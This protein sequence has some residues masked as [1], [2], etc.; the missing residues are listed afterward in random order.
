MDGMVNPIGGFK[1]HARLIQT[2][3]DWVASLSLSAPSLLV[4]PDINLYR[5]PNLHR[6]S[7]IAYAERHGLNQLLA[8]LCH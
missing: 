2:E 4:F 6:L 5:K 7:I 3:L 8:F 1:N